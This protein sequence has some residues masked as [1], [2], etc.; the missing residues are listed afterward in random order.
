MAHRI[1]SNPFHKIF[2]RCDNYGGKGSLLNQDCSCVDIFLDEC[3]EMS[4]AM[5]QYLGADLPRLEELN[6]ALP[7]KRERIRLLAADARKR[8]Q[9]GYPIHMND[10]LYER[11][12]ER[13]N[14]FFYIGIHDDFELHLNAL[15][16]KVSNTYG[17]QQQPIPPKELWRAHSNVALYDPIG[18]VLSEKIIERNTYDIRLYEHVKKIYKDINK[19]KINVNQT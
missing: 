3:F 11:A 10:S 8:I 13:L 15:F 18:K 7:R 14:N 6:E 5:C 2:Q 1:E 9:S 12:I 17:I 19:R 4:N 16:D